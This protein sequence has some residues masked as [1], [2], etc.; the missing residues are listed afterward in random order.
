MSPA[1]TAAPLSTLLLKSQGPDSPAQV[2]AVGHQ[3]AQWEW[4]RG[5]FFNGN[6]LRK[7]KGGR[8]YG[9]NCV[10][11]VPHHESFFST[12]CVCQET[13]SAVWHSHGHSGIFLETPSNNSGV[14]CG[15]NYN[16]CI[17]TMRNCSYVW[18][19]I[20]QTYKTKEKLKP[21][22]CVTLTT[23]QGLI[24]CRWLVIVVTYQ[25]STAGGQQ[26]ATGGHFAVSGDRKGLG[27]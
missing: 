25:D 21:R 13:L 10:I 7:M 20:H 5:S 24:G 22:F 9:Y 12:Y 19:I 18:R 11:I 4:A 8:R 27:A 17:I 2:P 15:R 26:V 14:L 16:P 1:E 23:F 6:L 3:E